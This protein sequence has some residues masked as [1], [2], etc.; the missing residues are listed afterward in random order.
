LEDKKNLSLEWYYYVL[1][2]VVAVAALSMTWWSMFDLGVHTLSAP[3]F[4]A[5]VSS[6]IFDLG[7]LYLGGL[8]IKYAKTE[9]SGFQT[10]FW[11]FAFIATSTYIV[12]QHAIIEGYP[13]AGI[14]MFAAAPIILGIIFKATLQYLTRQQ[15]RA[16]GR[17]TEKLPSVGWLTWVRYG[18]QAWKLASVAMQ[19]RIINAADKLT[20]AED[21]HGIFGQADPV[22]VAVSQ[23]IVSKTEQPVPELVQV[24]DKKP[25]QLS[26]PAVRPALT[27]PDKV[28]LPVW[29]PHEPDIKLSTLVRTCLDNGVFDLETM[30]RYAKDIK[31]QEVNKASLR[32]TLDRE[33]TKIG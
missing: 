28:S 33:K 20:L 19:G 4:I 6:S 7:G 8:S 5:A 22:R 25:E 15:R 13:I 3:V 11:T 32:K 24:E 23:P 27:S 12:V 29:L 14:V 17:V 26:Q 9:D 18:P 10:E 21:R 2:I 30:F 31:G 16:A 1:L